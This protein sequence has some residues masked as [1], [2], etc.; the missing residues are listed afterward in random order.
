MYTIYII[1]FPKKKKTKDVNVYMREKYRKLSKE[2]KDKKS[3]YTHE[4]FENLFKKLYVFV[5]V[6]KII[7]I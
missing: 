7:F 6:Q 2:E 5:E 4:W 1:I 3:Q